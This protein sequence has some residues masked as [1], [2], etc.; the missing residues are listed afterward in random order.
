M[1]SLHQAV[2]TSEF[3][4]NLKILEK[5]VGVKIANPDILL[6]DYVEAS[7]SKKRLRILSPSM[8]GDLMEAGEIKRADSFVKGLDEL[9]R[10]LG[11]LI[12]NP[13]D[14]Q[15]AYLTKEEWQ[16]E[17]DRINVANI[18]PGHDW[19]QKTEPEKK[20]NPKPKKK[21]KKKIEVKKTDDA[22]QERIPLNGNLVR[23]LAK[24]KGW[25]LSGLGREIGIGH[26]TLMSHYVNNRFDPNEEYFLKLAELLEVKPKTIVG[27]KHGGESGKS[28]K[29]Y[30]GK[31]AK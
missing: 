31:Y 8:N 2:R 16:R 11:V 3:L 13:D 12:K 28:G 29:L 19:T 24:E 18:N 4:A 15:L 14:V 23:K 9:E 21:L 6:L 17:I 1:I 30:K 26:E 25:S 22:E 27:K 7:P 5:N 10:Q 20:E